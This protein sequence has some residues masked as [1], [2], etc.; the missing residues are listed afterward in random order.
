MSKR[1]KR[2]NYYKKKHPP[3]RRR[4]KRTST[5]KYDLYLLKEQKK[6]DQ[7]LTPETET[8]NDQETD[9]EAETL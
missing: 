7:S 3:K 5:K 2:E 4:S 8:Q 1:F 6:I 9:P